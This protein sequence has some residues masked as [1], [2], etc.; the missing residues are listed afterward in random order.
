MKEMQIYLLSKYDMDVRKNQDDTYIDEMKSGDEMIF[1]DK[2]EQ[3]DDEEKNY[4]F[5]EDFGLNTIILLACAN[6]NNHVI[7]LQLDEKCYF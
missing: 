4:T 7:F 6:I 2:N 1:E 5:T 3:I